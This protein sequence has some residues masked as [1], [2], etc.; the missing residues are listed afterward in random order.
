MMAFHLVLL[1]AV[2]MAQWVVLKVYSMESYL[3]ALKA[4]LMA[5]YSVVERVVET[6][7]LRWMFGRP[8]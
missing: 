3:V 5:S 1:T 2:W 4:A 6:K 7:R 8:P